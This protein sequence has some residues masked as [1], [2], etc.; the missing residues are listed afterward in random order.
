MEFQ[1]KGTKM[2]QLIPDA[3][4]QKCNVK[5]KMQ[6]QT[7]KK[8]N[9]KISKTNIKSQNQCQITNNN[10]VHCCSDA[11]L[12]HICDLICEKGPFRATCAN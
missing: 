8:T 5:S 1:I 11:V 2:T 4:L 7:T 9:D 12:L 10:I 3:K 6:Y